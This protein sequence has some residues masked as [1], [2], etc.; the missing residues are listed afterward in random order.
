MELKILSGQNAEV[1]SKKMPRQFEEP[2]RLDIIKRAVEAIQSNKRQSYGTDPW[3]GMKHSAKLSR[4]RRKYKGAYG[5]GISRVPRKI[6]SRRGTQFNWVAANAPCVVGGR[7]AHPPKVYRVLDKKINDK[8]RKK[9][10]RSALAATLNKDIVAGRG[11]VLPEKFPFIISGDFEKIDKTKTIKDALK[12]LGLGSDL[13]R[14]SKKKVRAGKGKARGRKFKKRTSVLLVVSGKCSLLN[15]AKNIPGI[16]VV[17]IKNIN[18][19][20]LAPGAVPGRLA[21]FTDSAVDM[22]SKE[23]LFM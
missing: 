1:G 21:L 14:G 16:N 6:M 17:E 19:E 4:R 5:K 11:H 13:A 10:I 15:A 12:M 2:V 22:L 7:M 9:A 23:K 20:L 3:A 18:A 8:E